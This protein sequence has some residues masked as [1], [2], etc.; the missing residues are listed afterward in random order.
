M[1]A[2][3]V[4]RP[5]GEKPALRGA[6]TDLGRTRL[7]RKRCRNTT[8]SEYLGDMVGGFND[9][10]QGEDAVFDW[11]RTRKGKCGRVN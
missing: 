3:G 11:R 2:R 4:R 1:G 10:V 5:K 9:V 6:G 8:T 7:E